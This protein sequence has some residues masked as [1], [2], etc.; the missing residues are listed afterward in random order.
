MIKKLLLIIIILG[1]SGCKKQNEE[2]PSVKAENDNPND[3][4]Y[5]LVKNKNSKPFDLL[6]IEGKWELKKSSNAN[7]SETDNFE[8]LEG[9]FILDENTCDT[10]F[11]ID[12][13]H[14]L[15]YYVAGH[16]YNH[17]LED[18]MKML[19]KKLDDLFKIKIN[20]FQGVI[21]TKCETPFHHIY[22]FGDKLVVWYSGDYMQFEKNI[23]KPK[24][25]LFE[26]KQNDSGVSIY[27]DTLN[28]TC[29]CNETAFDKAYKIFYDESPDYLQRNLLKDLPAKNLEKKFVD[30]DVT[31]NWIMKDT[32]KI[33]MFFQGGDNDYVFY[34]NS[35]NKIE[36][37]EY[38]ALP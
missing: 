33:H 3:S 32:L 9:K 17:S 25:L 14:N 8:L 16:F 7:S 26:C 36:Y 23:E 34:K 21:N 27:D 29:V 19:E 31:Y 37:K 11:E 30:A 10:S 1:F 28:K 20:T 38:L 6:S 13:I 15:E 35:D 4:I 12:S 22:V 5:L 24:P 18:E 2:N